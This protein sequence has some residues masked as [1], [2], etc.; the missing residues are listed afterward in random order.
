MTIINDNIY[1]YTYLSHIYIFTYLHTNVYTY[2][3]VCSSM[4]DLLRN[5]LGL[6]K[7]AT[8]FLF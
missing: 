3:F 1:I 7:K 6:T 8:T 5:S 2:I 4:E